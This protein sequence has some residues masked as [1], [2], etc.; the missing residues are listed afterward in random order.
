M[1]LRI[2]YDFVQDPIPESGEKLVSV[3]D[4]LGAGP[5][6]STFYLSRRFE[7]TEGTYTFIVAAD[8]AAT[9]WL[10]TNQFDT[11]IVASC[12]LGAPGVNPLYIPQGQYR[13]D[14]ILQN[15][16]AAPTP[17]YFTLVIKR[18]DQVVYASDKE[19]WWLDDAAIS[20]D[21]LPPPGDVRFRLPVFSVM[22]NWQ[23]GV[24]ERLVWQ[25][26]VMAS[27]T[28]AE[29]RRSVRR[30]ARRYFEASFLR[31]NTRRSRLDAFFAG[32]GAGHFMLPLWHEQVRMDDGIDMGGAGVL[33]ENLNLREFRKGDLVFVTN[34]DPD[35]YDILQV[36]DMEA[37]R[38]S[39]A[40][41]PPRAWPVGTRIF[42]M[43]MARIASQQPRMSAITESVSRAEVMF[44]LAEPY[45]I[46]PSWG[47]GVGGDPLF[48]FSPEWASGIDIDFSRKAFTI[49]NQTGV[50]VVVDHGKYT[51]SLM[52]IK[53]RLYGRAA[54]YRMRQFL[55][56]ARGKAQKFQCPTFMADVYP[57]GD[58]IEGET[59]LIQNQGF[60]A[61][62]NVPQPLRIRL[63]FQFYDAPTIYRDI[64]DA[65]TIYDGLKTVA[66][67]V[68]FDEP[69]PEIEVKSLKR[70]SFISDTRFDQDSFEIHHHSSN[71]VAVDV[72]MVLRQFID[73]RTAP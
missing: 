51:T 69:L 38:F 53:V 41:P 46:E 27:E 32:V 11:R 31:Q 7:F 12:V 19:G 47:A 1:A 26:D 67:E 24:T 39:W 61:A 50:P 63:A 23:N 17:C 62:M 36:G 33:L 10:G 8:D 25:T 42:P 48:R 18:G 9:L 2:P 40:F 3:A 21:D 20:D 28:D 57:L 5:G 15:L 37:H 16:P 73:K 66:E 65:H 13:I 43:R 6:A 60:R 52:Q 35:D 49:D 64:V 14:V 45:Y 72:A 34:G 71:Q 29:Q 22:P 4:P 55:Q 56:A 59:M 44:D 54:A 70:I 68:K 30:N 58:V